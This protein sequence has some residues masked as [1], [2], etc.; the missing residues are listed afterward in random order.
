MKF[1]VTQ[2][3]PAVNWFATYLVK[4]EDAEDSIDVV[5]LICWALGSLDN[6]D[7]IRGM[8]QVDG[9]IVPADLE[10]AFIGYDMAELSMMHDHERDDDGFDV[11]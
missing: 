3:I 7:S 2:M 5:P 1:K 10:P 6:E 4:N 9:Q 8:I 11:N